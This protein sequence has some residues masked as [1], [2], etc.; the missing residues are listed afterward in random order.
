VTTPGRVRRGLDAWVALWDHREPA[1]ALAMV[2]IGVGLCILYDLLHMRAL[3]V[4]EAAWAAPPHGLA[5]GADA[6]EWAFRWLGASP[7]TA[8]LLWW[9]VFGA[10]MA[11][12]LGV[13][14]RVAGVVFVL[15]S[16]Q[17]AE[18]APD[19][20]R[21]IDIVLRVVIGILVLSSC[22]GRWSV[23][24]WVRR[25]IGRPIPDLVPAWP[26]YLL[27]VQLVWIY[28]SGGHNKTGGE[29][30]VHGDFAALGN[31]LSDPHFARWSTDWVSSVWPLTQVATAATMAFE[32]SAPAMLLVTWLHAT[33]DRGGWVRRWANRLRLRWVWIGLGLCFHLGIAMFMQLGIFPA[34]MLALYPV[35]LHASELERA[36][37]WLGRRLGRRR[38]GDAAGP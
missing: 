6:D 30:G 10:A 9:T 3:G 8:R 32:L 13:L 29:W 7:E 20:D 19:S 25:R 5:V 23:D 16:A 33:R 22:H 26:R 37:A 31:I 27:V 17:L 28:F 21:G 2:R 15:V 36:E 24:V 35:L 12:T 11:L 4:I 38:A 34:A 14:T 1:T 18:F